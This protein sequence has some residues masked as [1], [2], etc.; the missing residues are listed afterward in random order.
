MNYVRVD[1]RGRP[2]AGI[3]G[4]NHDRGMSVVSVVWRQE[5]ISER[6]WSLFLRCVCVMVCVCVCVCVTESDHT[7]Q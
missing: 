6:G 2:L 7:Q 5:Q 3:A 1:P 4:S